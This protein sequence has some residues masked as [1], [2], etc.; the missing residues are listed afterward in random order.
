MENGMPLQ[1]D[2]TFSYINQKTSAELTLSDLKID[3]LYNTYKYRGLPP[4]PI[5][6]PGLE[7]LMAAAQ[8]SPNEYVY[9]LNDNEGKSYF[10][11]TYA[12]HL[13]Y[14]NQYLR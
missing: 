1:V 12:Q 4:T 7:T 14:K 6:N 8:P 10:S 13:K 2:A 9:F 3:S 5:S 11:I